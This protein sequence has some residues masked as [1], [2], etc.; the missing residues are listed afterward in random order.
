MKN[1]KVFPAAFLFFLIFFAGGCREDFFWMETYGTCRIL[2]IEAESNRA[3]VKFETDGKKLNA[4]YWR[5]KQNI[6]YLFDLRSEKLFINAVSEIFFREHPDFYKCLNRDVN[7][8]MVKDCL[9]GEILKEFCRTAEEALYSAREI[10]K[11][12]FP[13]FDFPADLEKAKHKISRIDFIAWHRAVDA[14][15]NKIHA[16][17]LE[18]C[19]SRESAQKLFSGINFNLDYRQII[20]TWLK[21]K[22]QAVVCLGENH[23]EDSDKEELIRMLEELK[24]AGFKYLLM[25]CILTFNQSILD[26][27]DPESGK[28]KITLL[29]Y[30]E[31]SGWDYQSRNLG[32][33]GALVYLEAIDRAKRL[34]YKIV[35]IGNRQENRIDF[36]RNNYWL[37]LNVAEVLEKDAGA[38]IIVFSGATHV[39]PNYVSDSGLCVYEDEER[40]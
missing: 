10:I 15:K 30:L 39:F 8:R 12:E 33:K 9:S 36:I 14:E 2:N 11:A 18:Y 35:G 13:A 23:S 17:G 29:K 34:G 37:A 21:D 6:E 25:E 31:E 38:K 1:F 22:K 24:S 27:Y 20:R 4:I 7:W 16:L 40:Y 26:D 28:G 3:L 32:G 5:T 19:I